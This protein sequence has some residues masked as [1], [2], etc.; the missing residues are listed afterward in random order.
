MAQDISDGKLLLSGLRKLRPILR[1]SFIGIKL[2]LIDQAMRAGSGEP[3]GR[4]VH[5]N[6]GIALPPVGFRLVGMPAPQIDNRT[7]VH[8]D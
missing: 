1:Y 5:I 4:R 3:L 6:Q 8:D 7:S 2:A